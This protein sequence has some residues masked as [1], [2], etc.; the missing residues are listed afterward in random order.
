MLRTDVTH[1][2][3]HEINTITHTHSHMKR[4]A[5]I[6]DISRTL[7]NLCIVRILNH[8]LNDVGVSKRLLNITK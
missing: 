3:A 4:S 6:L 7:I 1:T 8:I 5:Q 2:H